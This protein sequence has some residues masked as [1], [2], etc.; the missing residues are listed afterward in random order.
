MSELK[1]LKSSSRDT[2][3]SVIGNEAWNALDTLTQTGVLTAEFCLRTFA[4]SPTDVD[5]SASVMPIMKALENELI[6][7]YYS[8][9]MAFLKKKYPDPNEYVRVNGL[10]SIGQ[11]PQDSRR[12]ILGYNSKQNRYWY[13]NPHNKRKNKR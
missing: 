8:P 13:R 3:I 4:E 9:Y 6:R 12:K 7:N 1:D 2:I 10:S 5:F 11:L